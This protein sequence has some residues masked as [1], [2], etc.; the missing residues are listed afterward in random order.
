ME[1]VASV[2]S[3]TYVDLV[4]ELIRNELANIVSVKV[5]NPVLGAKAAVGLATLAGSIFRSDGPTVDP[6]DIGMDLNSEA[7]QAAFVG[8]VTQG[9]ARAR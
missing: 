2:L 6:A 8:T 4:P 5:S 9:G 1:K 7:W 3:E